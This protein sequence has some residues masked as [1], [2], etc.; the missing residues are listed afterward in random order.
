MAFSSAAGA[1]MR[2]LLPPFYEEGGHLDEVLD[3]QGGELDLLKQAAD[4]I[5]E[6]NFAR[7]AT[8]G[9]DQWEDELG[10]VPDPSLSTEERQNRIIAFLTGTG[11]ATIRVVEDVTA[12]FHGGEAF[13]IQDHPNYGVIISFVSLLGIP[14]S[15]SEVLSAVRRVVPAHLTVTYDLNWFIW[16]ELNAENWTWSGLDALALTWPRLQRF[17]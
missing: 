3:S 8:W 15:L 16:L 9:L 1:R 6:Q 11:T 10:L 13:A 4:S 17:S 7:T 5:L 2:A 14:A 12:V